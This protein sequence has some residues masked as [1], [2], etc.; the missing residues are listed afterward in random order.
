M[1]E[2]TDYLSAKLLEV[3]LIIGFLDEKSPDYKHRKEKL[4]IEQALLIDILYYMQSLD[5]T[6]DN[7]KTSKEPT[8]ANLIIEEQYIGI[9]LKEKTYEIKRNL[10]SNLVAYT[11]LEELEKYI[12][13]KKSN[14]EH[15]KLDLGML[16]AQWKVL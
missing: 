2:Q 4:T 1:K 9:I 8:K 6:F 12:D 3:N 10:I 5:V 7:K 13:I 14:P 15:L 16:S 11:E